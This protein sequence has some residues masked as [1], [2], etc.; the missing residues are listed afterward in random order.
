MISLYLRNL[1][2][3]AKNFG[4][5]ETSYLLSKGDKMLFKYFYY[6]LDRL[7]TLVESLPKDSIEFEFFIGKMSLDDLLDSEE[8]RITDGL[9]QL[10]S[11]NIIDQISGVLSGEVFS[12]TSDTKE[13]I[14]TKAKD[15]LRSESVKKIPSWL[16]DKLVKIEEAIKEIKI[17]IESSP[18]EEAIERIVEELLVLKLDSQSKNKTIEEKQRLILEMA[19]SLKGVELK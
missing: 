7:V 3:I 14:R 8:P 1:F 13:E 10:L 15:F 6:F 9:V 4:I 19:R 2:N 16:E 17:E 11:S 5:S 18:E 12:L